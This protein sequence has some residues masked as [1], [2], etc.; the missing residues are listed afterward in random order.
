MAALVADGWA[1]AD[2]LKAFSCR[3]HKNKAVYTA[4]LVADGWAGAEN[5]EKEFCDQR[6]DGWT[7]DGRTNRKVAY[8]VACPRLKKHIFLISNE[9]Y[10]DSAFWRFKALITL[11]H[12]CHSLNASYRR[13]I[14]IPDNKTRLVS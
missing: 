7:D 14:L 11:L 13:I 1:G 10:A 4:A 9:T 2:N 6:T 5:L 8:R 3:F 12:G